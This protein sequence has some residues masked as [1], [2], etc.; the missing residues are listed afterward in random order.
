MIAPRMQILVEIT[1][2][3][4]SLCL[5][6]GTIKKSGTLSCCARGGSWFGNCGATGNAKLQHTWYEGIQACKTQQPKKAAMGK[7]QNA[8]EQIR[9]KAF[10]DASKF[11][12]SETAI[13][14]ANVIAFTSGQTTISGT[15][16]FPDHTSI[17]YET[18]AMPSKVVT[19]TGTVMHISVN[20]SKRISAILSGNSP[21][22]IPVN[23][24]ITPP[25]N[26]I[27]TKSDHASI[28]E[29]SAD[30]SPSRT[31]VSAREYESL[32]SIVAHLSVLVIIV[33]C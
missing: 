17:A 29:A 10:H 11:I 22:S 12:N 32:L 14:V 16:K 27:I 3:S 2:I 20:E 26:S 30:M 21:I 33:V 8:V 18:G 7:Q 15:N 28:A 19:T 1:T 31:S 25:A 4:S 5:A 23:G 13:T 24:P 6:C 9:N